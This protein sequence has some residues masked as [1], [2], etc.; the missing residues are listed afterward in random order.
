[1]FYKFHPVFTQIE[2]LSMSKIRE[3]LNKLEKASTKEYNDVLR[4]ISNEVLKDEF[5]IELEHA[6]FSDIVD[7]IIAIPDDTFNALAEKFSD[8]L[9]DRIN[10]GK[11]EDFGR[12]FEGLSKEK[13]K[14]ISMKFRPQVIR[15]LSEFSLQDV[16]KMIYSV[17]PASRETILNQYKEIMMQ[18]N[19]TKLILE[20]TVDNIAE[21]LSVLP[22]SIRTSFINRHKK[23]FES[24]EFINKIKDATEDSRATL[25]RWLPV[26]L[27]SKIRGLVQ[28]G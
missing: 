14:T 6:T 12:L 22:E 15:K 28:R 16:I 9:S 8:V 19:F 20:A 1:L 25:L 7:L 26:D 11:P 18:P 4:Q 3:F 5:K 21:F 17:A 10:E 13:R 27:S 24:D 23:F 2:A